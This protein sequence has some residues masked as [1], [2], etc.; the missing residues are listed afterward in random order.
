MSENRGVSEVGLKSRKNSLKKL[1]FDV[2]RGGG[3]EY[4]LGC[5]RPLRWLSEGKLLTLKQN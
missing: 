4:V 3:D 2:D 1:N 5:R